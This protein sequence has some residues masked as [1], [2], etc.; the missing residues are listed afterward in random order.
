MLLCNKSQE[1]SHCAHRSD[2]ALLL[3]VAEDLAGSTSRITL[4]FC[5]VR[6][7]IASR[8]DKGKGGGIFLA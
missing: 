5:S 1:F 7:P 2:D 4:K 8:V 3:D 6:V